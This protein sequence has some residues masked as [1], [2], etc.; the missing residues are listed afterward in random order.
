MEKV[1]LFLTA[2]AL[3]S[4]ALG[5]SAPTPPN[6]ADAVRAEVA[7]IMA[8]TEVR[9]AAPL[10]PTAEAPLAVEDEEYL[11][12]FVARLRVYGYDYMPFNP[13]R[14]G[15][16]DHVGRTRFFKR[17]NLRDFDRA[18]SRFTPVMLSGEH[19][20]DAADLSLSREGLGYLISPNTRLSVHAA[21]LHGA[22]GD[23]NSAA[24]MPVAVDGLD[25]TPAASAHRQF[26]FTLQAE[27]VF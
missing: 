17:I 8:A 20:A 4:P 11:A 2:L 1:T 23:P 25:M 24:P 15:P 18:E 19:T 27:I 12:G 26:V 9:A 22:T 14:F 3:A 10:V 7:E 6:S 21:F 5:Q 13:D 16:L